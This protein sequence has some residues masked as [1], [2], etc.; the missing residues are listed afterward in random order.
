[1]YIN[2]HTFNCPVIDHSLFNSDHLPYTLLRW[3]VG[4]GTGWV[5]HKHCYTTAP[6]VKVY[7]KG[8]QVL[9]LWTLQLL[10]CVGVGVCVCVCVHMCVCVCVCVCVCMRV[11]MC[12]CVSVCICVHVC[13]CGTCHG[14]FVHI[15]AINYLGQNLCTTHDRHTV[16]VFMPLIVQNHTSFLPLIV[17]IIKCIN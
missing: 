7:P 4:I 1:M 6:C 16:R 12:V 5:I 13:A 17:S 14:I 11:C 2:K 3:C 8:V 9:I 10:V 15:A